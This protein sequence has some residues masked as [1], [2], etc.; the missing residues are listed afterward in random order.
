VLLTITSI[1]GS[2]CYAAWAIAD[3]FGRRRRPALSPELTGS[4]EVAVTAIPA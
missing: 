4:P 3:H 1:V 2:L